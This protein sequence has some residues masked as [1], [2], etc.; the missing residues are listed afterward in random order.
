MIRLPRRGESSS[1]LVN[2]PVVAASAVPPEPPVANGGSGP[3]S[4]SAPEAAPAITYMSKPPPSVSGVT[5][6]NASPE[7]AKPSE[8]RAAPEGEAAFQTGGAAP[9]AVKAGMPLKKRLSF[10]RDKKKEPA[11][12]APPPA[13]LPAAAPQPKPV[14]KPVKREGE[15]DDEELEQ[16][17]MHLELTHDRARDEFEQ[18]NGEAR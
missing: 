12:A 8:L 13:P 4:S 9:K 10:G 17:L 5:K 2:A 7:A 14:A 3:S 15:M 6:A 16:Y 18:Q 1:N 11:A